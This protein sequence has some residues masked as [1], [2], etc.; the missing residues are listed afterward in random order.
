M[1]LLVERPNERVA[2]EIETGKSNIK[3]NLAKV[4]NADF[5]R[6]IM[7]A[8]SPAALSPCHQAIEG[9]GLGKDSS[10]EPMTWLDLGQVPPRTH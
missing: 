3:T 9:A 8:T 5:D 7:V 4:K 10:V 1:D 2:I 6:L